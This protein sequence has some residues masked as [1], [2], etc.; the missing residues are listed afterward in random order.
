MLSASEPF[1]SIPDLSTT[2]AGGTDVDEYAGGGL[3]GAYNDGNFLAL[4]VAG[5]LSPVQGSPDLSFSA[6]F[7]S[8][9]VPEPGTVWLL[10]AGCGAMLAVVRMRRRG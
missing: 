2:F 10:V 4:G 8:N 5:T 6:T 1:G 7:S 9:V 3:F